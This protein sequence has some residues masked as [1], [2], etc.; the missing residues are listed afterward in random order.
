MHEYT[1]IGPGQRRYG[2]SATWAGAVRQMAN[3]SLQVG[4]VLFRIE[5][6]HGM[7]ALP[8]QRERRRVMVALMMWVASANNKDS[9]LAQLTL[10]RQFEWHLRQTGRLLETFQELNN[11]EFLERCN[12]RAAFPRTVSK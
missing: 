8:Y 4:D 2:S 10:K 9:K 5:A 11:T 1:I 7:S 12:S 6:K 3:L